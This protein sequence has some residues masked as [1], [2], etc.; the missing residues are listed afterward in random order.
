VLTRDENVDYFAPLLIT[1]KISF[2]AWTPGNR[3]Q[4]F[5][6]KF[7]E[8]SIEKHELARLACKDETKQLFSYY[9]K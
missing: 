7:T 1:T 9:E 8:G 2:M 4:P 5:I 3:R 6:N